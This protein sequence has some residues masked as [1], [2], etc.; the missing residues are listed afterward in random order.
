MSS[1]SFYPA[2]HITLGEGGFVACSDKK[3][4]QVV[5]SL[6]DWGRGCYCVGKKANESKVGTCGT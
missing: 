2:P 4:E 3:F 6:R 5:R 1:C